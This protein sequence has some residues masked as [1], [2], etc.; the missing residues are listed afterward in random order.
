[1]EDWTIPFFDI[2]VRDLTTVTED[3]LKN[4]KVGT[5]KSVSEGKIVGQAP[6]LNDFT[7]KTH[8]KDTLVMAGGTSLWNNNNNAS[9]MTESQAHELIRIS[10]TNRTFSYDGFA[11]VKEAGHYGTKF[12]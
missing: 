5:D 12:S 8:P 10:K 3:T 6:V 2:K 7:I 1:M 9:G 4:L 11:A